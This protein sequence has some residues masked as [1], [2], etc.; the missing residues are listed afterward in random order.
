V[1]I[2]LVKNLTKKTQWD[3]TMVKG[4]RVQ[5][6]FMSPPHKDNHI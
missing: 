6:T 4:K 1:I 2:C 5:N 3:K